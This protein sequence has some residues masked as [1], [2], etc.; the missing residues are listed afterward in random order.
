MPLAVEELSAEAFA[1]FG[2]VVDAPDRSP[3]ASGEAWRWWAEAALLDQADRPYAVGYLQLEPARRA[4]DW[5]ERHMRSE[6]MVIPT[7]GELL[8]YVA[9]PEPRD[10]HVFR[11]APGQGAI[12]AKGTWHGAPL[13]A[14]GPTGAI[15]LLAQDTGAVDTD[16]VQFEELAVEEGV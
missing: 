4:F 11:L 9:A 2:R 15:V 16:K 6:E 12:L 5:A 8:L 14:A 3:D 13:A 7:N 10:F 1:Q